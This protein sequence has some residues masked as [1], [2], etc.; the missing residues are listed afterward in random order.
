M[1]WI[2]QIKLDLKITTGDGQSYSPNYMNVVKTV[3]YNIAEFEFPGIVGT[4]VY[5][6]T[7][8]GTRHEIEIYFQGENNIQ[9]ARDFETSNVDSRAWI[10]EHPIHGR[11]VAQPISLTFDFNGLNVCK[12]TGTIVETI[13]DEFPLVDSNASDKILETSENALTDTVSSYEDTDLDI[14]NKQKLINDLTNSFNAVKNS[15]KS[16]LNEYQDAFNRAIGVIGFAESSATISITNAISVITYPSRFDDSVKNKLNM[17]SSQFDKL[18]Q[19]VLSITNLND[20]KTYETNAGATIIGMAQSIIQPVSI[21]G[22]LAGGGSTD[23]ENADDVFAIIDVLIDRYNTF[24]ENITGLQSENGGDI[25]SYLPDPNFITNLN[26]VVS[27]TVS[28]LTDLAVDS[29]QKRTLILSEDSNVIILTHR[30]YGLLPDD[31]T[32]DSFLKANNF[33]IN[34]LIQVPKNTTINYYV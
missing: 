29:K 20:K 17:F 21:F 27:L 33:S 8:K 30:F 13:E 31:S 10:I 23:Y 32:I 9:D 16:G 22:K 5:R 25:D 34:D 7:P 12:I 24:I 3:N 4:K 19:T 15:V 28:Q 2:Q 18:N 1:T 14:S 11:L 26:F 6:G